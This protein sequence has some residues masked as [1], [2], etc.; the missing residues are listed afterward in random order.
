MYATPIAYPLSLV[1]EKY[2]T[3]YLLNPM[4]SVVESFRSALFGHTEIKQ[5]M[6]L[7]GWGMTLLILLVGI[8]L[9]HRAEKTFVDTV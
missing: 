8:A 7:E 4:V 2:Q 5:S 3:L 9:F 1:P 6:V